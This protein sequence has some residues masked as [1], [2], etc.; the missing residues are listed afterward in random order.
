MFIKVAFMDLILNAKMMAD[1]KKNQTKTTL[2]YISQLLAVT[3][4]L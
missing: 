4:V 1:W 3:M 2:K